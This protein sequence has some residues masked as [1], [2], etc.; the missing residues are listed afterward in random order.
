MF[1][2]QCGTENAEGSAF[3]KNCGINLSAPV[4]PA[5]VYA[6]PTPAV[7]PPLSSN[8]VLNAVK[9]IASS[10]LF[11]VAVIALSVQ[12][13][14]SIIGAAAGGAI[15]RELIYSVLYELGGN[16]PYEVYDVLDKIAMVG[17]GPV[18][19]GT[20]IG[21]IPTILICVGLWLTYASAASRASDTMKTSG[22]TM[23]KVIS[24]I[25]LVSTC[26]WFAIIE[27][28]LMLIVIAVGAADVYEAGII[29]AI[30]IFMVI[31]FAAAFVLEIIYLAKIIK[32]I[33]TA[34]KTIATAVPSDKVS[35]FVAV[36]NFISAAGFIFSLIT[37]F[38][39]SAAAMTSLICFGI[40]I[41]K[42]KSAMRTLMYQQQIQ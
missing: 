35:S 36:M 12:I 42:Y 28:L 33:N 15:L 19:V 29:I 21:L 11:L 34:K 38:I 8:P 1:C 40:L 2:K 24:I 30:L 5:P 7:K 10:P 14:A 6:A 16:I 27:I 20:I 18:V 22:L 41:F 32:S 4:Q 9:K 25:Q 17:S 13:L 37:S 39:S 3:C 26:I 23:I 31:L